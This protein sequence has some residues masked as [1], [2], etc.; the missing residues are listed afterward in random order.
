MTGWRIGMACGNPDIAGAIAKVK[1]NTDSGIFNAIQYA[2][3]E[4]LDHCDD[5]TGEMVAIYRR[6][7][8]KVLEALR[9]L[10]WRYEPPKGTFYLWVPVPKGYTSAEFC[11]FLFEKCAV[12]VA[13]GAAYG[14]NGEGYVRFSL[15]VKEDRLDEALARMRNNLPELE[16]A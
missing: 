1:S 14:V 13:P 2:G 8:A 6:R 5:F 15:T 9:D 16:F 3:I 7:R 11:D 4:A 12:V 10:G